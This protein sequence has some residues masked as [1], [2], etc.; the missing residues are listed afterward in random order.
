M[1]TTPERGFG[2]CI[3]KRA[4]TAVGGI[5]GFARPV[6]LSFGLKKSAILIGILVILVT[7]VMSLYM[8]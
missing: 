8:L 2:R 1:A 3:G 6:S 7:L 5:A 4:G